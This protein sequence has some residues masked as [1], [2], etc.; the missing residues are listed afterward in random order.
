MK[1]NGLTTE[2][3]RP[4]P[5]AG[6][7]LNESNV[8]AGL[9]KA[10]TF[11]RTTEPA[12]DAGSRYLPGSLERKAILLVSAAAGFSRNLSH[13][14]DLL[15]LGFKQTSD[16]AKALW[17]AGQTRA[18][19][20][21]VD[22][23]LPALAGWNVAERLLHKESSPALILLTERNRHFDLEAAI[24]SGAVVDKS[25]GPVELLTRVGQ[26]LAELDSDRVERIA[27]QWLLLRWLRP[28]ECPVMQMTGDRYRGI[29]E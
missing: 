9:L 17:L 2:V 8:P 3:Q 13:T 11:T 4:N 23:D 14:A 29:N 18:A 5:G 25:A 20:A 7:K 15:E 24:R 27:R 19:V 10:R 28:F 1:H 6:R 22:L 26:A 16:P 12:A 21:F